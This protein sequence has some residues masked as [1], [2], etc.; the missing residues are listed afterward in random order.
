MAAMSPV[1]PGGADGGVQL[2]LFDRIKA[3]MDARA[4]HWARFERLQARARYWPDGRAVLWPDA[5]F[6]ERALPGSQH[7]WRCWLCGE[8]EP[9]ISLLSSRHG[10]SA[11]DPDVLD[12]TECARQPASRPAATGGHRP[13]PFPG[14][15]L[16]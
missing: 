10:L 2:D 14:Q 5:P 6:E 8:V 9:D 13:E 16:T 7:G 12:R 1:P 15:R 3:G 4:A 11:A